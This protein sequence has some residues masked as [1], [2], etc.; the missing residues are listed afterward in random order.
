M[1][2]SYV[3]TAP[4][5]GTQWTAVQ[6]WG[7]EEI[8]G[9]RRYVRHVRLTTPKGDDEQIKLVYDYSEWGGVCA[10]VRKLMNLTAGPV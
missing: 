9:E 7:V 3:D 5:N 6:T 10:K 4:E 2:E 1:I 8:N